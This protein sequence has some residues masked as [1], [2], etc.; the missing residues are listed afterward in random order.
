MSQ[1][2]VSN[3]VHVIF[4]TKDRRPWIAPEHQQRLWTYIMG[5]GKNKGIPVLAI[6]GMEDHIHILVA[7]PASVPLAK[8]VQMIKAN[9]SR[10]MREMQR[11]FEWQKGYGGFSVGASAMDATIEYIRNQKRHHQKRDYKA[12]FLEFLKRNGVAYDPKY[13]FA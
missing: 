3:R 11:D 6:G 9:S 10:F 7:L 1:S 13:V 2:L 8:A 5:I 4:S 12:E